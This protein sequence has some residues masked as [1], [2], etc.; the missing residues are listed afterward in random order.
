MST[1]VYK[2]YMNQSI[3][4]YSISPFPV[5]YI[6]QQLTAP[7]LRLVLHLLVLSLLFVVVLQ[8]ALVMAL[9]G[10]GSTEGVSG[11][12]SSYLP[13]SSARHH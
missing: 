7:S 10:C 5:Y 4:T 12:A 13:A 6:R 2:I 9:V 1:Y 8:P 3:L 11:I